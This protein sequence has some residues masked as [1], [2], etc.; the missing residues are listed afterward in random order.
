MNKKMEI[1]RADVYDL[2][3]CGR[4][5]KWFMWHKLFYDIKDLILNNFGTFDGYDQQ[6][7][8]DTSWEHEDEPYAEHV[9]ILKRYVLIAD[10]VP[11]VFHIPTNEFSY[12]NFDWQTQHQS[13]K[14]K[15]FYDLC[16][17][18][19]KGKKECYTDKTDMSAAKLSLKYLLIK[20]GHL[21]KVNKRENLL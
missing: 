2:H 21:Y 10:N 4:V 8:Y 14:F 12:F 15:E 7:W 20:F 5:G 13:E 19:I 1:T 18:E 6:T 17:N 3:T 11:N 16:K 9:H